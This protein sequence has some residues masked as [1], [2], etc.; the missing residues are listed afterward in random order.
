MDE[1]EQRFVIKSLR[2]QG[3]GGKTIHAQLSSILASIAL[4]LSTV[5]RWL[6]RF[7]E[8]NTSC[9]DVERPGRP[10]VI[11]GDILRKFLARYPFASAK[12]MSR[13]F[14]VSP[15]SVKEVPSRELG[16]IKYA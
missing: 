11:I 6:R 7:K 2:L 8:G 12:V 15:S 4:S 10:M 3:L 14:G 1:R 9:E 5:Q 16:F 13:D